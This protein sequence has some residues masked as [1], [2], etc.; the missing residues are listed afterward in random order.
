MAGEM[1]NG[2]NTR[3]GRKAHFN[4]GRP[5][6]FGPDYLGDLQVWNAEEGLHNLLVSADGYRVFSREIPPI[7]PTDTTIDLD[8]NEIVAYSFYDQVNTIGSNEFYPIITLRTIDNR[9]VP[10]P[11]HILTVDSYAKPQATWTVRILNT[12]LLPVDT[13]VQIVVNTLS[14]TAQPPSGFFRRRGFGV[15]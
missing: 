3:E 1:K 11:E 8:S 10:L 9:P 13:P 14:G 6:T 7:N 2:R 4:A 5:V 12:S 15:R